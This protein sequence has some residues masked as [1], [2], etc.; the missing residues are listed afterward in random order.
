MSN[1]DTMNGGH[2]LNWSHVGRASGARYTA[3]ALLVL[4]AWAAGTLAPG[5]MRAATGIAPQ[6]GAAARA[7]AMLGRQV[8]CSHRVRRRGRAGPLLG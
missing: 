5:I 8:V 7:A 4:L 2:Y 1:P 3:G 6:G